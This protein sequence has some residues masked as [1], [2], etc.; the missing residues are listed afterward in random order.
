M[1]APPQRSA[2]PRVN[3]FGSR[4]PPIIQAEA[5]SAPLVHASHAG[6]EQDSSA[7][8]ASMLA[9]ASDIPRRLRHKARTRRSDRLAANSVQAVRY[10]GHEA[11]LTKHVRSQPSATWQGAVCAEILESTCLRLDS[12]LRSPWRLSSWVVD[13][14]KRFALTMNS[15][16]C[17]IRAWARCTH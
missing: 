14:D 4:S 16:R 2:H 10:A 3:P 6:L 5:C 12:G 15:Y 13:L 17:T 9:R 8:L 1:K 7:V 11:S